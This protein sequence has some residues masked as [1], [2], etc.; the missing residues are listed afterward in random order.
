MRLD[1]L[2]GSLS[3][4]TFD[5]DHPQSD[6]WMQIEGTTVTIFGSVYGGHDTG[7]VYAQDGIWDL[8]FRYD[9][10]MEVAPN[11]DL[12]VNA[13]TNLATG[14]GSITPTYSTSFF[15]AGSPFALNAADRGGGQG[16]ADLAVQAG[17]KR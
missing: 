7:S 1:Q 4:I 11:G 16:R 5:F 10:S 12:Y 2:F 15:T 8:N 3:P 14:T 17:K 9:A 13:T 6:V